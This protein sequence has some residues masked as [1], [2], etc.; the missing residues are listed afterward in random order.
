MR[1]RT[2]LK[3]EAMMRI[4][5]AAIAI[6]AAPFGACAHVNDP[7]KDSS[8]S[9]DPE[10]TTASAEGHAGKSEFYV[11][12]HRRGTTTAVLYE[13]GSVT[14]WPLWF[15]DPFE[16]KGND[17]THPEPPYRDAAD[18]TFTLNWVDYLHTGYGPAR[19]LLNTV[20]WPV[21]A[22]VTPP[23][24]LLESDGRISK[25]LAG[26]DHD[27]KHSNPD[28][29]EPPDG[30]HRAADMHVEGPPQGPVAEPVERE[31][32]NGGATTGP[33]ETTRPDDSAT[34]DMDDVRGLDE[35]D[36]DD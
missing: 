31:I 26:Y 7:Y 14:H 17:P 25:G 1:L 35:D 16:D 2:R 20:L 4:R 32:Q 30:H 21:S 34:G 24:T 10:M 23:G 12:L 13:N 6:C 3:S 33:V 5:I 18:N 11:P 8:T 9:I 19:F 29:R 27:A 28:T 15:E 22:V 36:T